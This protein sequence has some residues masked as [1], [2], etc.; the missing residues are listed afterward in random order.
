MGLDR[1]PIL[2]FSTLLIENL[3]EIVDQLILLY[4][5]SY[6]FLINIQELS[7]FSCSSS[8][9]SFILAFPVL[10]SAQHECVTWD[11]CSL[12]DPKSL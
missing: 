11:I 4:S 3:T 6:F 8:N 5:I 9:E 10:K 7:N 2:I 1:K 12:L